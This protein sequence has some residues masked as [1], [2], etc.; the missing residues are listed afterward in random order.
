[1]CDPTGISE[2]GVALAVVGAASSAYGA[3]N[4]QNSANKADAYN[5]QVA[6]YQQQ[7]ATQ[8][9]QVQAEQN[10]QQVNAL[11]GRQ[12]AAYAAAG[13]DPDSGSAVTVGSQTAGYGALDSLAIKQQAA[14]QSWSYG[15]QA[16]LQSLREV[17]PLGAGATSLLSSSSSVGSSV[18]N[19]N[20]YGAF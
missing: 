2:A 8:L 9:G 18:L 6:E 13:V 5:A 3:Y 4:Q 17:N 7:Q 15:N 11:R 14:S 20:R 16:N 1:M 10:D 12:V 19:A